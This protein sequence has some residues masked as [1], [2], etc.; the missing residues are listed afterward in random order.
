[1]AHAGASPHWEKLWEG[2]LQPG[3]RFDVAGVS[4]PLA[5]ELSRRPRTGL[6]ALVLAENQIGDQGARAIGEGLKTNMALETIGLEGCGIGA[7]RADAAT[8]TAAAGGCGSV[9]A[10]RGRAAWR[11]HQSA[12]R[13]AASGS[14][15]AFPRR[16][17]REPR[18][19]DGARAV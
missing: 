10:I 15:S 18:R 6:K 14:E 9:A 4:L 1:M 2:G 13:R 8:T 17:P 19:L 16:H 3:S 7:V 11:A 12:N 5:A